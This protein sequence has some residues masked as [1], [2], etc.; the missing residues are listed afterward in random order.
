MTTEDSTRLAKLRARVEVI[1]FKLIEDEWTE[2]DRS[3][4]PA[5]GLYV[6]DPK[7]G[8]LVL[9]FPNHGESG[10][11]DEALRNIADWCVDRETDRAD[12]AKAPDADEQFLQL[13]VIAKPVD[14]FE[15]MNIRRS[16]G[17]EAATEYLR[18][19][20]VTDEPYGDKI[21]DQS[22]VLIELAE[23]RAI[24]DLLTACED[25][26]SLREHTVAEVAYAIG[27]SVDRASEAFDR[28]VTATRRPK[29]GAA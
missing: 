29:H 2:A 6:F 16:K 7:A 11:R 18:G 14:R 28:Y 19:C 25:F 24:A 27:R 23:T 15:A 22:D 5:P 12:A 21:A 1:G 26:E 17:V 13:V 10:D 8:Q 9:V 3:E 4:R 20:T